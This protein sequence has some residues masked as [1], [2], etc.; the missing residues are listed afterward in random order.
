MIQQSVLFRM[1]AAE[2]VCFFSFIKIY[3]GV[4]RSN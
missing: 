4:L 1:P 3:N 2:N